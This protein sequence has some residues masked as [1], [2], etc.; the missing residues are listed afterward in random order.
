MPESATLNSAAPITKLQMKN[1]G[2]VNFEA[3]PT[4]TLKIKL[5]DSNGLSVEQ[6]YVVSVV[7]RND[8]PALTA[9]TLNVGENARIATAPNVGAVLAAVDED[10]GCI[11]E[12]CNAA[13]WGDV[14]FSITA[15]NDGNGVFI[16]NAAANT[17]Q[18]KLN[19]TALGSNRIKDMNSGKRR[20]D[21]TVEVTDRNSAT[22]P[23]TDPA[24][25]ELLPAGI[26]STA[27]ITVEL[28]EQND[29][30]VMTCP[31]SLAIDENSAVNTDAGQITSVDP[32]GHEIFYSF[33]SGNDL[34]VPNRGDSGRNNR[35]YQSRQE[36][37]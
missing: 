30:P 35:Q 31:T 7:N 2:D 20:Y 3:K 13:E 11:D 18:L 22:T 17:A 23:F 27:T 6:D 14:S 8:A 21:L 15:G 32:E 28:T 4:W 29:P 10:A 9:T 37:H 36:Y 33:V 26:S 25:G 24:T 19:P 12:P 16:E 34:D 5:E 1:A